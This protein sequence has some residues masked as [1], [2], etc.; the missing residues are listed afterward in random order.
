M[1]LVCTNDVHYLRHGD[2]KP[3]DI[4]LCIGTGKSVNDEHRLRYHGDQ[5]FLKSAAQMAQVFGDYPAGDG[6][7]AA[8]R[9]AR[10]TS[11]IPSGENHLP[12]FDVPEGFTLEDYFE[13]EARHGFKQRLERLRQLEAEDKLRH[14]IAEYEQRLTYEIAMIK[15]MGYPGYFLIVWDFI[16]YAREQGIPVGPGR[17]SAAGSLVAWC[18]ARSPTSIRCTTTCSSSASSTPSACRCPISTSTSASAAAAR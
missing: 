12:N 13:H 16:R 18:A 1:P 7:H 15:Q 10:A 14:T 11:T 3:H 2:D 8:H 17:G 6:Q 9:R 5:F 4:L